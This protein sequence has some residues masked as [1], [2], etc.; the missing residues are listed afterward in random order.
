MTYS[1]WNATSRIR[2]TINM[3][4]KVGREVIRRID[5]PKHQSAVKEQ[6]RGRLLFYV[7]FRRGKGYLDPEVFSQEVANG[8]S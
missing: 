3:N 7:T 5:M 2:A 4:I 1:Q 6:Q 8:Q